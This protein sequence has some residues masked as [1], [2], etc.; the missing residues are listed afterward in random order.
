MVENP[1][2]AWSIS[3]PLYLIWIQA[4]SNGLFS[5]MLKRNSSLLV[6]RDQK[7][8]LWTNEILNSLTHRIL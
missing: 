6:L 4:F 1:G 3:I 5:R 2:Y 8:N 7:M